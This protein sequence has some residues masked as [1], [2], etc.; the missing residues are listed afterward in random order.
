MGV[1]GFPTYIVN[2]T[3]RDIIFDLVFIDGTNGT[4]LF[5]RILHIPADSRSDHFTDTIPEN[6]EMTVIGRVHGGPTGERSLDRG[7]AGGSCI[8]HGH[9]TDMGVWFG[10]D[11]LD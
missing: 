3:D 2:E 11:V 4:E 6:T 10:M 9:V 5:N 7:H 1:D 8:L